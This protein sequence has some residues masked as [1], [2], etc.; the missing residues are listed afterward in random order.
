M[1]TQIELR[2]EEN[3]AF[4]ALFIPPETLTGATK[5]L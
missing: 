1:S 2:H 5:A 3:S 4:V